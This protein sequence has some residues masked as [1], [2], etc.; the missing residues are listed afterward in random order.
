M[1]SFDCS[2]IFTIIPYSSSAARTTRG[3]VEVQNGTDEDVE[4]E[5]VVFYETTRMRACGS[6]DLDIFP[7]RYYLG[8]V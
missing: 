6:G 7:K 1:T 3:A 2:F 4:G 5:C 8:S